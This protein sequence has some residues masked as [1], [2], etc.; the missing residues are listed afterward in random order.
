MAL[1]YTIR[2]NRVARDLISFDEL[3]PKEQKDFTYIK[4]EDERYS[5]RFARYRGVVYDIWEFSPLAHNKP[6]DTFGGWDGYKGDSYFSGVLMRW[7]KDDAG[8]TDLE[9]VVMGRYYS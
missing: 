3:T 1:K 9:R 5:T 8:K 2:T 6:A 7:A 4:D